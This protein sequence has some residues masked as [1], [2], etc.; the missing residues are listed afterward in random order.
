MEMPDWITAFPGSVIVSDRE[1][2]ILWMN[3]KAKADWGGR[4]LV[5]TDMMGCHRERSQAL[6][7]ELLASGG[8]N[9]YT[10]QDE[11]G[12]KLIYQTAWRDAA[13][14]VAGLVELVMDAPAEIPNHAR[15]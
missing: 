5:G 6:I 2:R 13:G 1:H 11:G 10:V 12:K 8:S 4:S 3:D 9:M 7:R 14:A 15:G